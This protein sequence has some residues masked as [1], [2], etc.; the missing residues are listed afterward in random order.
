MQ[1]NIQ[2][3]RPE[4]ELVWKAKF[5]DGSK[6]YQ[7]DDNNKEHLFKE[8]LD[9]FDTLS[10]F[11]LHHKSKPLIITVDVKRGLISING[12]QEADNDLITEKTNIRLIHFRRNKVHFN[13]NLQRTGHDIIYFIGY[14]YLT[15]EGKNKKVLL[16]VTQS[17]NI[18]LGDK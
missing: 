10:T 8:V 4:L 18:I 13:G 16:Q 6:V 17:G 11:S 5:E 12:I 15:K 1:N 7:Y 3:E 2:I 9:R 14:Q